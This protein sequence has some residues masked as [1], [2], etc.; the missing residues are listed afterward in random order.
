MHSLSS[1]KI[2]LQDVVSYIVSRFDPITSSD[3]AES[4][5]RQMTSKEKIQKSPFSTLSL[6][7][8]SPCD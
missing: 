8:R 7:Q 6:V 4:E 3:T 1:L 2:L 5:L